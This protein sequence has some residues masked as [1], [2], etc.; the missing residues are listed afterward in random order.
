MKDTYAVPEGNRSLVT[1]D[2]YDKRWVH[3]IS[4]GIG[5]RC[6][7]VINLPSS[8]DLVMK[9]R[10]LIFLEQFG[11]LQACRRNALRR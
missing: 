7:R 10:N 2:A 5:G 1:T 8:C 4:A 9:S 11:P 6:V 3:N